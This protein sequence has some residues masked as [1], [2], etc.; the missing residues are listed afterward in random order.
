MPSEQESFIQSIRDNPTDTA[1]RLAYADWL[2]ERRDPRGEYLR[3]DC[4]LVEI[5][6]RMAELKASIDPDWLAEVGRQYR[7]RLESYPPNRKIEIVKAIR[8]ITGCGLYDAK[9]LSE[10]DPEERILRENLT[11]DEAQ[12]IV[13]RFVDLAEVVIEPSSRGAH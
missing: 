3:L 5:E 7:A 9:T 11:W 6:S 12:L 8:E 1:A 2:D 10:L 13:E 4:Q